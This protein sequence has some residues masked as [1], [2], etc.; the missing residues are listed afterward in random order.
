[1]K[2]PLE[3][4]LID[5]S[6][7]YGAITFIYE[8]KEHVFYTCVNSMSGDRLT[9]FDGDAPSINEEMSWIKGTFKG[10]RKK[11]TVLNYVGTKQF[12]G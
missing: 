4:P 10:I 7:P 2:N 12:E 9:A 11:A 1:M 8:G 5:K 6:K 3:N